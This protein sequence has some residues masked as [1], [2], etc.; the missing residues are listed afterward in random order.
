MTLLFC[1]NFSD[2]GITCYIP[3]GTNSQIL[4]QNAIIVKHSQ[5]EDKLDYLLY[6][7]NCKCVLLIGKWRCDSSLIK[8][9]L[10][11][12]LMFGSSSV[13]KMNDNSIAWLT[14]FEAWEGLT[15]VWNVYPHSDYDSVNTCDE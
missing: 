5:Q 9:I 3:L 12:L 11:Y 13:V 14:A 10:R 6:C 2:I 1:F 15:W 8:K 4:H 7:R